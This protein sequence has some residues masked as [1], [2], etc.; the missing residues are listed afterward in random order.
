MFSR[1]L[2]LFSIS[3]FVYSCNKSSDPGCT[4][5]ESTLV[6]PA[7]ELAS[8]QAWVSTNRPTAIL[9]PGGFYYEINAAGTGTVT[10]SVCSAVTVKYVGY[11]STGVKFTSATEE[12]VPSTFNLGGLILGWQ[13][14]LPLIKAGGSINLYLPPS[15]GYGANAAGTIP[16]NSILLFTI[17]LT[18]VQ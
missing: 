3:L 2:I 18:A 14:G 1:L 17:Q 6:V 5:T 11:L 10:P 15:L 9:H 4:F 7:S 16:P 13:R 12:T 8:L